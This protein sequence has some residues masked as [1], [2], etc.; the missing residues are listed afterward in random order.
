MA[1]DA[2]RIGARRR[3]APRG[4]R[5]ARRGG[6]SA[7][8]RAVPRRRVWAR[9]MLALAALAAALAAA[10]MLWF[11]DSG[12]VA[13]KSV[14][15]TGLSSQ[16]AQQI[17]ADLKQAAA[18]MTTLHVREAELAAAVR[19]HPTVASVSA[20]ARFP[21]GLDIAVTERRPVAL[22]AVDGRDRPVAG[23]GTVLPT[24]DASS[25]ELPTIEG[26]DISH[27]GVGGKALAQAE[28]LGAAPAPLARL[29]ESSSHRRGG[30]E[31]Q[32][33]DGIEL[34]FGDPG[35]AEAKWSAAAR[36]LADGGLGSLS[37]IDLSAPERPAVGGATA[38]PGAA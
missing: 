25:L 1:T 21:T 15:V 23:D 17:R 12:L 6:R 33:A 20:A 29:V 13:I 38:S 11:R 2:A 28:V 36:I 9:R 37:Y 22:L 24:I 8:S 5:R 31:V 30:V 18:G 32:L 16:D 10:Y 19:D 27:G 3:L 4:A 14:S 34:R 35:E 26:A 7:A